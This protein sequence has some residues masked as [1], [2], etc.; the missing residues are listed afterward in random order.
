MIK[1][2]FRKQTVIYTTVQLIQI[3]IYNFKNGTFCNYF[4]ILYYYGKLFISVTVVDTYYMAK[5]RVI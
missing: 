4:Y 5:S 1:I 3:I 2:Q